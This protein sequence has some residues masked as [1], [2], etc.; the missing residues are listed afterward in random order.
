[1]LTL[2]GSSM[3]KEVKRMGII[4]DEKISGYH[5]VQDE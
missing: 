1:V 3:R 5:K 4:R 2:P